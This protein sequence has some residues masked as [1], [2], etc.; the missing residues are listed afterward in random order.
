MLGINQL[1]FQ[2]LQMFRSKLISWKLAEKIVA[3]NPGQQ[4]NKRGRRTN[5]SVD[6]TLLSFPIN[7]QFFFLSCQSCCSTRS[8]ILFNSIYLFIIFYLFTHFLF[9][10]PPC[11]TS[12]MGLIQ[13]KNL[14]NEHPTSIELFLISYLFQLPHF[15]S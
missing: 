12:I 7:V 1:F 4:C 8:A 9:V 3:S 14:I 10:L 13:D 11:L 2:G 15:S 6:Q 5:R